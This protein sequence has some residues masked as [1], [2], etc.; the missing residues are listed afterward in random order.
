MITAMPPK[1][2]D[3]DLIT[4]EA[5]AAILG[6]SIYKIDYETSTGR[7]P[8]PYRFGPRCVRYSK[9][10]IEDFVAKRDADAK[11]AATAKAERAAAAKAA[12]AAKRSR[13]KVSA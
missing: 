13:V 2:V 6:I 12:A 10:E 7:L 4:R 5:A 9:R 3:P 11:A 1:E 8:T